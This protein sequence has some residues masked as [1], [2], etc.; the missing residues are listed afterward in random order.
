MQPLY[1]DHRQ[2]AAHT[3]SLQRPQAI[4]S[5]YTIFK[6]TTGNSQTMKPLYSDHRQFA[7]HATS[8]QRPQAIHSPYTF[9]KGTAGNSRPTQPL[10]SE[11]RQSGTHATSLQRP[12]V[13]RGPSRHYPVTIADVQLVWCLSAYDINFE[14]LNNF[15]IYSDCLCHGS[16]HCKT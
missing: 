1:S 9:F 2:F 14:I 16:V 8:L 6:A 5:P 7:A 15:E 10:Y 12:D 4:R 13:T 3:T 11:H